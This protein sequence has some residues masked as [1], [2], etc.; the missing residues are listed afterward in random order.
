VSET[1]DA[2]QRVAGPPSVDQSAD[3]WP[4]VERAAVAPVSVAPEAPDAAGGSSP[5]PPRQVRLRRAPRYRAFVLTGA[6]VGVLVGLVVSRFSPT[7]PGY[8]GG[9][10]FGYLA[11]VLGL[12]GS[13]LGGTA[14]VLIERSQR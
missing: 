10:T 9:S 7:D 2:E 11:V 14:A 5:Q 3:E 12:I 4:T 6:L 13:V 8:S 1:P